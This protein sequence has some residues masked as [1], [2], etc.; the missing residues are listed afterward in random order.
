[1]NLNGENVIEG[2]PV[3]KSRDCRDTYAS[4]P[5]FDA[6]SVPPGR[7]VHIGGGVWR[8]TCRACPAYVD[9]WGAQGWIPILAHHEREHGLDV[10]GINVAVLS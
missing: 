7:K 9:S 2:H 4:T 5:V 6:E 1:M 3:H 10:V 8:T